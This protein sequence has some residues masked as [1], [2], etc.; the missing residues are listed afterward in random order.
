LLA[1][2]L[3]RQRQPESETSQNQQTGDQQPASNQPGAAP[4]T[5]ARGDKS[6]SRE[7]A[8]LCKQRR[9]AKAAEDAVWL[10][11]FQAIF[12]SL[13]FGAVV[14]SLFFTGWAAVA[15]LG[16]ALCSAPLWNIL[17]GTHV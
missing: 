10:A 15:A 5:E 7:D 17:R 4:L 3:A 13:G 9:M 2:S 8:D 1:S 16:A 11:P 6:Q 12:S 14:F